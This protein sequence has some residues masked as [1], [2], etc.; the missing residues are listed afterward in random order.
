MLYLILR[1]KI[2]NTADGISAA[3]Y[4]SKPWSKSSPKGPL[5][6]VLLACFPSTPSGIKSSDVKSSK[7]HIECQVRMIEL[8]QIYNK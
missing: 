1:P 8:F 7:K 6:P 2:E 3:V 4:E 5:V